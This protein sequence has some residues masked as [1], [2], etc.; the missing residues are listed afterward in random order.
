MRLAPI[1]CCVVSFSIGMLSSLAF[2]TR[3]GD[4]PTPVRTLATEGVQE[5]ASRYTAAK[6]VVKEAN[7]EEPGAAE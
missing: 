2:A 6:P 4:R 7:A 1:L 3:D 5:D